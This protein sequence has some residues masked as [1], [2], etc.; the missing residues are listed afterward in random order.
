[1]DPLGSIGGWVLVLVFS[2]SSLMLAL[3]LD[4]YMDSTHLHFTSF[5]TYLSR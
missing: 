5:Y 2:S 1:M 3:E 4:A